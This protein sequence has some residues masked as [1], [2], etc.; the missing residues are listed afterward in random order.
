MTELSEYEAL[1]SRTDL[2]EQEVQHFIEQHPRFLPLKWVQNHGVHFNLFIRKPDLLGKLAADFL[3]L[4]KS[5]VDWHCVLIEIEK[6]TTR[7]FKPKTDE[8]HGEFQAGLDQVLSWKA[9][10]QS[11]GRIEALKSSL[12]FLMGPM[13]NN[14]MFVRYV[15]VA[16]RRKEFEGNETRRNLFAARRSEDVDVMTFDSLAVDYHR[17]RNLYLGVLKSNALEIHSTEFVCENMFAW[18]PTSQLRINDTLRNNIQ[19][20]KSKWL[21][22]RPN[23]KF[24]LEESLDEVGSCT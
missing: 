6:P 1:I 16:G 4:S 20:E 7:L 2:K 23:G 11:P 21:A 22:R 24:V 13:A 5:S 18:I 17:R 14:P 19:Q 10:L 9:F 3:F 15:L 8:I 12:K